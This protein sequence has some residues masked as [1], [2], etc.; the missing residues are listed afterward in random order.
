VQGY[1]FSRPVP[2]EEYESFLVTRKDQPDPEIPEKAA[3]TPSPALQR[4]EDMSISRIALALSS[5]FES[6]Y[7]VDVKSGR[8]LEFSSQG[9][10]QDLQIQSSGAATKLMRYSGSAW[11]DVT[12]DATY[13]HMKTYTWYRRDKDGNPMDGGEAFATGKVIYVDGDD[14]TV[15]TVFVCEVE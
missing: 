6:I 3:R 7:Y 8:Y 11:V 14:V 5:G 1:Y 13:G 9:K 10:Y 2:A 4:E 15:K 12:T